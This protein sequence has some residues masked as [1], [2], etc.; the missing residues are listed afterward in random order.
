MCEVLM[1]VIIMTTY[2]RN[3]RYVFIM[4]KKCNENITVKGVML[5]CCQF[6]YMGKSDGTNLSKRKYVIGIVNFLLVSY[7]CT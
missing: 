6:N 7:L 5:F 4:V 1:F 2:V 3:C